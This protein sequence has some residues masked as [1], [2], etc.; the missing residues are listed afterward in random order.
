M[1]IITC[2]LVALLIYFLPA[3]SQI[4]NG[5]KIIKEADSTSLSFQNREYYKTVKLPFKAIT[6]FDKRFDTT[7]IGYV[8]NNT[9]V[10]LEESFSTIIN[11]YFK[12]NVDPNSERSLIIFIKSFWIQKGVVDNLTDKK[13][14]MGSVYGSGLITEPLYEPVN[15]DKSG[16]CT[17]VIETF[18]SSNSTFKSLF[19]IDTFFL[20]L[21]MGF[22][23]NNVDELFFLPFDSLAHKIATTNIENLLEKKRTLSCEQINNYYNTR[24]NIPLLK[25]SIIKKRYFSEL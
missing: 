21:S 8:K 19:K 11:N 4:N 23:K 15:F 12:K 2:V 24:F 13:V 5:I 14:V 17:V 10:Q 7:K 3:F 9:K 18:A 16:S 20:N 22:G 1:K 25:D 6:V